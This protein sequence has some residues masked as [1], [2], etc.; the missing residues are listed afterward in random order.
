MT[1]GADGR[2]FAELA[3]HLAR[4]QAGAGLDELLE[5]VA[6]AALD[7]AGAEAA[8]ATADDEPGA[9]PLVLAKLGPAAERPEVHQ[10]L[11]AAVEGRSAG[12][13]LPATL[14]VRLRVGGEALGTIVVG[15]PRDPVAESG[16]AL[17]YL[18]A[19]VAHDVANA[20]RAWLQATDPLTRLPARA[21]LAPRIP[22]A[23]EASLRGRLPLSIVLVD[24][25]GLHALNDAHG[26]E[27][28]DALLRELA[29]RVKGA[30]RS[31][32]L[33]ARWESDALLVL[34][35]GA[36]AGAARKLGERLLAAIGAGEIAAGR[37]R[38]TPSASIGV[39]V[40]REGDDVG[41]L[42][43]RAKQ[44]VER[45]KQAGHGRVEVEA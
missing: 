30:L 15:G 28:G 38:V 8:I 23:L 4:V 2:V 21:W 29:R 43:T 7:L 25:D 16:P 35:P 17:E 26:T 45:A 36:D 40:A 3:A 13:A 11:L 34:A 37:A 14:S 19:S 31:M 1:S 22:G 42:L 6:L 32:D 24:A 41:A 39:G 18:G 20:R 12:G 44:A 9:P 33:A 27:A 10:A 5:G